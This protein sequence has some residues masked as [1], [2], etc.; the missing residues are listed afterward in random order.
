MCVLLTQF[1]VE[2][3][4]LLWDAMIRRDPSLS[5]LPYVS[6]VLIL[7]HRDRLIVSDYIEAMQFLMH[8]P[9][10]SSAS[11]LVREAELLHKT[12]TSEMG[13]II[14][15]A[16]AQQPPSLDTPMLE[17]ARA[18]LMEL[19]SAHAPRVIQNLLNPAE[20]QGTPNWSPLSQ[21]R[22]HSESTDTFTQRRR[23]ML[24][25]DDVHNRDL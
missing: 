5:L 22:L 16:H 3:N 11:D 2:T 21:A 13:I 8:L 19:S 25:L 1:P 17:S 6:T 10:P 20:Q 24:S 14:L 18:R 23:A 12:P 9:T 4:T 15:R 7:M